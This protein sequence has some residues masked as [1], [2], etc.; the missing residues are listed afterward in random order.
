[1]FILPCF[2]TRPYSYIAA[3]RRIE[4]NLG[5]LELT[6]DEVVLALLE[7]DEAALVSETTIV[8]LFV[9]VRIWF[10]HFFKGAQVV[11]DHQKQMEQV[12]GS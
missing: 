8:T 7:K 6:A 1:L 10:L 12:L 4:V 11:L 5:L 9:Y 3:T 2:S